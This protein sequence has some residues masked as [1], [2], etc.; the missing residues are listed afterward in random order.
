MFEY[1]LVHNNTILH[2]MTTNGAFFNIYRDLEYKQT[3]VPL[4]SM[5]SSNRHLIPIETSWIVPF[6]QPTRGKAQQ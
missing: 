2:A 6:N 4:W 3:T 5:N 1:E